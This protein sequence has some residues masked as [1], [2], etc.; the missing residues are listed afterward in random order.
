M[1]GTAESTHY[2]VNPVAPFILGQGS[3]ADWRDVLMREM[4]GTEPTSALGFNG[5]VL[6]LLLGDALPG[7]RIRGLRPSE[8]LRVR[9]ENGGGNHTSDVA[10]YAVALVITDEFGGEDVKTATVRRTEGN[11]RISYTSKLTTD[12]Y[13]YLVTASP[14]QRF[15]Q[16][17]PNLTAGQ[18]AADMQS[19][20]VVTKAVYQRHFEGIATTKRPKDM[21]A[22]FIGEYDPIRKAQEV[23]ACLRA[24]LS[25]R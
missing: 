6:A 9:N 8:I 11:S 23:A 24:A 25:L 14:H 22:T 4:G 16:R 15:G 12:L 2:N 1:V 17:S 18:L 3:A 5:C 7:V 10:D 19:I 13:I 20:A 21:G